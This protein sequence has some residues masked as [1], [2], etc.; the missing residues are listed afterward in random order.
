MSAGTQVRAGVLA[1]AALAALHPGD[2]AARRPASAELEQ[3]GLTD[4]RVR[5]P[6]PRHRLR[7]ALMA[8][9]I[10][11]SAAM[12]GDGRVQRF[13]FA[14]LLLDVAYQLQFLKVLMIRP[15]FAIGGN[16]ANTKQAMP[17]VIQP[18][19]FFGYQGRLLGA[20]A[21]YSFIAAFP[22]TVGIDDG[23]F[24]LVQPV[25]DKMHALQLEV[26]LTTKVDRGALNFAV[27]Y[28]GAKTHLIHLD[29]DKKVWKGVLTLSAGWFFELGARRQRRQREP[30]PQAR[31]ARRWPL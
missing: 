2:A 27:R 4:P 20:A 15:S 23:H 9:A 3:S 19:L 14:P 28:G 22:A 29:L 12:A 7:L 18:A 16:V 21:G 8:D 10:R 5:P 11:A 30:P 6:P 31:T 26:S 24:G 25:L 13:Y 17:A 1:L